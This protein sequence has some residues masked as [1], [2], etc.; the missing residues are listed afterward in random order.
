MQGE[1]GTQEATIPFGPV[2]ASFA[3]QPGMIDGVAVVIMTLKTPD[4]MSVTFWPPEQIR[5][6][7]RN[8]EQVA[9]QAISGLIIPGAGVGDNGQGGG[10]V[11]DLSQYRDQP[12]SGVDAESDVP[13]GPD[14][15][16]CD[17]ESPAYDPTCMIHGV[18]DAPE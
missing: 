12:G 2:P 17:P 14:V 1:G 6:M 11:M 15:C 7:A 3:F 8:A 9:T 10:E 18:V 13:S 16:T 4:A 5:V